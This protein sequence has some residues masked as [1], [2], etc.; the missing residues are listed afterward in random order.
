M[1]SF[2]TIFVFF[3]I[4]R[5]QGQVPFRVYA[6]QQEITPGMVRQR[7]I[8]DED[9]GKVRAADPLVNIQYYI[10][11]APL[12]KDSVVFKKIWIRGQWYAV[13]GRT[14]S[15]TPVHQEVPV[16]KTLVPL[17]KRTTW[18]LHKGDSLGSSRYPSY[19]LNLM[20]KNEL[21]IA[22]TYKGKTAYLGVRKI[23]VLEKLHAP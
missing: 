20:K 14:I 4:A 17:Q 12:T 21:I 15:P 9:E 5:L 6:Y 13:A 2:L 16:K 8:P 3:F 11:A 1:K 10:Y 23:T 7:D 19:L 22:Y 18:Q